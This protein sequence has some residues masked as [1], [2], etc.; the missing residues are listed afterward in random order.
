MSPPHPIVMAHP[1]TITHNVRI[2]MI[3]SPALEVT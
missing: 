3:D 1:I 2:L